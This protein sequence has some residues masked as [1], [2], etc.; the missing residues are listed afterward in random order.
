[1]E[2]NMD[3]SSENLMVILGAGASFDSAHERPPVAVHDLSDSRLPLANQLFEE[4]YAGFIKPYPAIVPAISR[5]REGRPVEP[6]LFKM[7][8][9]AKTNPNRAAQVLG[10]RFYLRDL[11]TTYTSGWLAGRQRVTNYARLVDDVEAWRLAN[12]TRRS[13]IT[14]VPFNYDTLLEDGFETALGIRFPTMASYVEYRHATILKPHGSTNWLHQV[15]PLPRLTADDVNGMIRRAIEIYPVASIF[16]TG[17]ANIFPGYPSIPAIAIPVDQKSK[18][19]LPETHLSVLR[20]RLGQTD[21]FLIIGWR[22]TEKHFT[23]LLREYAALRKVAFHI[24]A[25]NETEAKATWQSLGISS[26]EAIK[27]E[28]STRPGFSDFIT[29]GALQAFLDQ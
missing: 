16:S 8:E 7:Q 5:L 18:F 20:E 10:I 29:S 22:G 3:T 2:A 9:E 19:E 25:A 14:Y 24:V 6:E 13:Q 26:T 15:Q 12:P 28:C 11:I 17:E 1:V 4:R 27:V 21:K 23:D